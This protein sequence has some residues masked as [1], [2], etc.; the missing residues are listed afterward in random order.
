[1]PFRPT[2]IFGVTSSCRSIHGIIGENG[3]AGKFSLEWSIIPMAFYEADTG[4]IESGMVSVSDI[5]VP[6]MHQCGLGM[7]HQHFMLVENFKVCLRNVILGA[8][9]GPC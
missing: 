7:V 6:K 4:H 2:K 3:P 9:G 8:E 1:V 5:P